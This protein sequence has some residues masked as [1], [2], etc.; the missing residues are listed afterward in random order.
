MQI[1]QMYTIH[2]LRSQS[3]LVLNKSILIEMVQE[4]KQHHLQLAMFIQLMLLL[5][6]NGP[7][8]IN[9]NAHQAYRTA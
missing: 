5:E 7:I 6:L 8:R 1:P 3:T 9:M 2:K 4:L